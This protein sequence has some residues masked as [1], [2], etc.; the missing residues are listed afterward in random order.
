MM[1]VNVARGKLVRSRVCPV[2]PRDAERERAGGEFDVRVPKEYFIHRRG[3]A[4]R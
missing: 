2:S 1:I 4:R 3:A